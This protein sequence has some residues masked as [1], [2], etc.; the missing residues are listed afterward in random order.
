M[1]LRKTQ[2]RSLVVFQCVMMLKRNVEVLC[3]LIEGVTAL[4]KLRPG[5]PYYSLTIK[6]SDLRE[7]LTMLLRCPAIAILSIGPWVTVSF[8][9]GRGHCGTQAAFSSGAAPSKLRT[10]VPCTMMRQPPSTA[11]QAPTP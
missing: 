2:C 3:Q 11:C 8:G 4:G 6:P 1:A 9:R 5:S 10:F 7:R